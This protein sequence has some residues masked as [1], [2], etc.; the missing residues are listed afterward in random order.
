MPRHSPLRLPSVPNP[1]RFHR[2]VK[3]SSFVSDADREQ[4]RALLRLHRSQRYLRTDD[5]RNQRLRSTED[6]RTSMPFY[7]AYQL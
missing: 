2:N 1:C 5:E 7:P 3:S 6:A 4:M